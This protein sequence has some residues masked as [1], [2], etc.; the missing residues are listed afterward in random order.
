ML[1]L[2]SCGAE[3]ES[4]YSADNNMASVNTAVQGSN[5]SAPPV[6]SLIDGLVKRLE[7][8]PDDPG[9][10]ALLARSYYFLGDK[11][12][13]EKAE[14]EARNRGYSGQI[15]APAKSAQSRTTQQLP[16]NHPPIPHSRSDKAIL[17]ALDK[18]LEENP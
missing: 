17:N 12:M 5:S 16:A 7:A 8:Y 2:S 10:W 4:A 18:L 1:L 13:A 11:K 9:G 6:A 14:Q 15:V 3:R